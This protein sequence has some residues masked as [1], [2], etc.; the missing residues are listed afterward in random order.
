MATTFWDDAIGVLAKVAPLLASAVG[1]PLAGTATSAIISALGLAPD[2][3]PQAA[4]AAVVNA[5]P[6]QLLA[7]KKADADFSVAMGRLNLDRDKLVFDDRAS[8][9]AREAAVK[10]HAPFALAVAVTCGFFGLLGAM[11]YH[12]LPTGNAAILNTMLGSLG[13]AW[14]MAMS[15]YFG[16]SAP[17]AAAAAAAAKK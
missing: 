17:Q 6:D 11:L 4:A 3:T 2:T 16:A 15:Y 9:R 7:L 1:G 14:V 5:S 8:A 13:T 12:D 10:D